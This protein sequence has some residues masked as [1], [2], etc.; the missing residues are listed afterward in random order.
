M[1]LLFAVIGTIQRMLAFGIRTGTTTDLT[2]TITTAFA[3]TLVFF[4]TIRLGIYWDQRDLASMPPGKN[5]WRM[6]ILVALSK[7]YPWHSHEKIR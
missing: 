4:L 7:N 3:P 2:I 6:D 1:L 5:I